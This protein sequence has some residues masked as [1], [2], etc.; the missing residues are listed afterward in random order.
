MRIGIKKSGVIRHLFSKNNPFK[1]YHVW[2]YRWLETAVWLAS[3]P[4]DV[5]NDRVVDL[6]DA[7]LI[8]K[9]KNPT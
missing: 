8:M 2:S 7:V 3:P 6:S 1:I 9:A 4:G 5:N